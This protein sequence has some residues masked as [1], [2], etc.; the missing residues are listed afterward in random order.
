MLGYWQF[1]PDEAFA[2]QG[3]K[4]LFEKSLK[5]LRFNGN[6]TST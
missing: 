4:Q 1:M 5:Y 6:T 3:K 2:K